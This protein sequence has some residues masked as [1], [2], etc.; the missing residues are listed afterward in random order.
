MILINFIAA[1]AAIVLVHE[2]GHFLTAKAFGVKIE[3]FS[4]GFGPRLFGKIHQST[5]YRLS[6]IPLGGYVKMDSASLDSKPVW[7][8]IVVSLAGPVANLVAAM[9]VFVCLYAVGV[10]S[11]TSRIGALQP[12]KPAVAA[13]IQKGDLV[14]AI[15]GRPLRYWDELISSIAASP[16]D[17]DIHLDVLRGADTLSVSVRP[18][19]RSG[20]S[21]IGIAPSS[22]VSVRQYGVM[23]S[24]EL[25]MKKTWK[26]IASFGGF[27][28]GF[29]SGSSSA[30]DIGGPVAIASAA[31][32]A[33]QAGTS[34]YLIVIAI[35]SVSLGM[36][37]LLPLP[38]LDGGA[39]LLYTYEWIARRP[40]AQWVR[41]RLNQAGI[42][43]LSLLMAWSFLNDLGR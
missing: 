12:D 42:I 18:E 5:E 27:V 4:I 39:V 33:A 29:A 43:G 25:G 35:L 30:S 17:T 23:G 1:F 11:P 9:V 37:N 36:F 41:L 34:S 24:I 32:K 20:R 28:V 3:S 22:E 2:L 13:G 19:N 21:F 10:P 15:N 7:K 8:R 40:P 26:E 14:T 38:I 6:V 16:R 31:N